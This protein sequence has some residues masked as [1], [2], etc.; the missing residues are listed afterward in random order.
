MVQG[1]RKDESYPLIWPE[2][3]I[4]VT[5]HMCKFQG[6]TLVERKLTDVGC[7]VCVLLCLICLCLSCIACCVDSLNVY[8][9]SCSNCNRPLGARD[10]G[11][12]VYY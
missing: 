12:P 7:C 4:V 11:M 1:N 6:P 9:H 5:C 3:P 10:K 8:T 2:S